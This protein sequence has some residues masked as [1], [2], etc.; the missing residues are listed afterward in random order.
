MKTLWRDYWRV[1]VI[2]ILGAV[3][4]FGGSFAFAPTYASST[5]LLVRGRDATFL[6][7][8][9][10]DL[11]AQPGVVDSSLAK[12]L[13]ETQSALLM[14]RAVAETVVDRL[15]LAHPKPE[16]SGWFGKTKRFIGDAYRQTR[17]ILT[18]GYYEEPEIRE[19]TIAA[20]HA[21]LT[22]APV[23]DSY[24]LQLT[25]TADDPQLAADIANAAADALVEISTARFRAD[26]ESYRDQIRVQLD[27]AVAQEHAASELVIARRYELGMDTS[28][29]TDLELSPNDL[30]DL[31]RLEAEHDIAAAR[32]RQLTSQFQDA[33]AN[34]ERGRFEVTR[35][36]QADVPIYPVKP[37]RYLYLAVGL[38]FGAVLGFLWSWYRLAKRRRI[39][40]ARDAAVDVDLVELE[41]APEVADPTVALRPVWTTAGD[42]TSGPRR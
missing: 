39:A 21:G 37:V 31:G 24:V 8:T 4:A 26:A 30:A 13:G 3:L 38:V 15:D 41:L 10:Q 19:G 33:Q 12:A 9:G 1:P 14:S 34:I 11:S 32:Y 35:V 42:G 27:E 28:G 36:D 22:A 18:F 40:A 16:P 29:H 5:K 23:R 7:T 17:A 6:T 20:V 25:A 2:G